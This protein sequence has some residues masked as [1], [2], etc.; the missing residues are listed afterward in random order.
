MGIT[1]RLKRCRTGKSQF[2]MAVDVSS[3]IS[4]LGAAIII[5]PTAGTVARKWQEV[6]KLFYQA[7]QTKVQVHVTK[8]ATGISCEV[9]YTV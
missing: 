3:Q 6:E 2:G 8:L 7:D 5:G 9:Q 4:H 1:L